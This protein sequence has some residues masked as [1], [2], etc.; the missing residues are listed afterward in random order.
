LVITDRFAKLTKCVALLRI[1]AISV[2]SAINYA[3]VSASEPPD[4]ILSDQGPQFRSNFFIAMMKMLGIETVRTMADH[5]QTNGEVERFN[6]TM[7]TQ[8]QHYVA[9]DPS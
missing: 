3:W 4:W 5:P 8:L 2:V 1:S 6:R 7:V 9:D